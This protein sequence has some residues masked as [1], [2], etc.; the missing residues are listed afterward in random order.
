MQNNSSG[1]CLDDILISKLKFAKI[2]TKIEKE[3]KI[4]SQRGLYCRKKDTPVKKNLAFFFDQMQ[5][6]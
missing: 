3:T 1:P 5:F 6:F 4:S 2:K